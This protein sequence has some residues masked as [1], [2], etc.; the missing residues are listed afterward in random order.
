[1][2][3]DD[4]IV[5]ISSAVGPAARMIVRLSG[6]AAFS[7]VA[8]L[9]S[10][11]PGTLGEGGGE[12]GVLRRRDTTDDC[13]SPRGGPHPNPLPAYRARGQEIRGASAVSARVCLDGLCF[14]ATLYRFLAPHSATGEDVIEIHLPGN[15][16]LARMT[17]RAAIAGGARSAEPGEFT[18]RSYFNSR[19]D[20]SA[21]EGVSAIISAQSERELDA[22]RRLLAGELSRRLRPMMD[23]LAQTLALVEA[24]IDFSGEEITVLDRQ[25]I[26]RRIDGIDFD[27]N[28]LL[29]ESARFEALSHEPQIV[30]VGRPNA[31]K[32]TLL[33]ALA[34][35]DR[36]IVS[37][38]AGTTRDVLS[39]LVKLIRGMV[40]VMDVAGLDDENS[41][42][43]IEDQMR[44]SS[45]RA[46]KTAD[47]IVLVRGADDERPEIHLPVEPHLRI[48]SKVDLSAK[49]R[50]GLCVSAVSGAGMERLRERLDALAFGATGANSSLALNAR[51]LGCIEDARAAIARA[52]EATEPELIAFDLRDALDSLGA[53]LGLVTPDDVLGRVFSTFCI[54]K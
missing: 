1:M 49:P 11:S 28:K 25:Q 26:G 15:P 41:S 23:S 16:L 54:G 39:A 31:G 36:A 9:L 40:K 14:P 51:H 50:D 45:L 29:A 46:I 43:E 22:A 3:S 13:P 48:C 33:N 19:L 52:R 24:E 21:A 44:Q 53:I 2:I 6:P 35:T 38:T 30:L 37:P 47:V 18:S 7:I 32:S 17:L 20:L 4:T 8:E 42:D 34:G 27:L 5:A 10:P 12:G